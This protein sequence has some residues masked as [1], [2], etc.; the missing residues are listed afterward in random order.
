MLE[1]MR[2]SLA[3]TSF[4]ATQSTY[5]TILEAGIQKAIELLIGEYERG[6]EH[7]QFKLA[8]LGSGV[9]DNRPVYHL[10][11]GFS[12]AK[13]DLFYAY[14]GLRWIDNALYLPLKTKIVDWDDQLYEHY[15]Y[16]QLN[17]NPGLGSEA[18]QLDTPEEEQEEA[19]DKLS[20]QFQ[21]G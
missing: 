1:F 4:L 10:E 21:D 11:M 17:L 6:R 9:V 8:L 5:R 15:E 12:R 2:L 14:R 3:P 20:I 19:L 18:F 7:S 16:H 13:K